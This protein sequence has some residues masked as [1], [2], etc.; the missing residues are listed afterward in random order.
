MI[1]AIFGKP[2]KEIGHTTYTL[3]DAHLNLEKN[4]SLN[5]GQEWPK[6]S[7]ALLRTLSW[8]L[9]KVVTTLI[10]ITDCGYFTKCK[11]G[12]HA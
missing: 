10:L 12:K 5:V 1:V 3:W 7:R 4:A 2:V 6:R 8:R 11:G 9:K